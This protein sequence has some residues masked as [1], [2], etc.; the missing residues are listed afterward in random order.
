MEQ[1]Q[2][3]NLNDINTKEL[4]ELLNEDSV[5]THLIDHPYFDEAGIKDWINVKN[6]TDS[7]EGCRVRAVA[8]GG[9][10]AGWCG[11]Q[12]DENGYEIA[13]VLSK[14]FWGSGIQI[15]KTLMEWAR[16]LGHKEVL[17]HLLESR[18]EYHTLASHAKRVQKSRLLGRNFTTFF[19][20]VGN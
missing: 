18:R 7:L 13:I 14:R 3:L 11:I 6:Q 9:T 16:Q 10:L 12:P 5:R 17:F 1:I 2:Y 19:F 15:F 20:A 8:I 4:I